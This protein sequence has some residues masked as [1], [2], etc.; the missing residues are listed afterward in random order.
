MMLRDAPVA[1]VI[2]TFWPLI[3]PSTMGCPRVERTGHSAIFASVQFAAVAAAATSRISKAPATTSAGNEPRIERC[4]LIDKGLPVPASRS[5][6]GRCGV[7][8]PSD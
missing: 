8:W 2:P 3:A 6:D 1:V 4:D 7:D 5:P